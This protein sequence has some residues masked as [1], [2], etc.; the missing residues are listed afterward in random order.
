MQNLGG[1]GACSASLVR[2][3]GGGGRRE[4]QLAQGRK[5]RRG[6]DVIT[7]RS[8]PS[9]D[10]FLSISGSTHVWLNSGGMLGCLLLSTVLLLTYTC[11]QT[12][13]SKPH[14]TFGDH[15]QFAI[16]SRCTV[17][18]RGYGYTRDAKGWI[19][20]PA[21]PAT[22]QCRPAALYEVLQ[23]HAV[24]EDLP[25]GPRWAS[26]LRPTSKPMRLLC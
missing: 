16:A 23:R 1:F 3:R 2:V 15:F 22:T 20:K 11:A 4:Y 21:V 19:T 13:A 24:G 26:F 6:Q 18:N 9:S 7:S 8:I 12:V 25:F 10:V 17:S 14:R 5:T